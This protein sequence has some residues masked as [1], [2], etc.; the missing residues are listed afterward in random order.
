M[1]RYMTSFHL[2]GIIPVSSIK[3]QYDMTWHPSLLPL[4]E[5]YNLVHRAIM[6]CAWAGCETIWI[7]MDPDITPIFRKIVGDYVFDPVNYYRS[8]DVDK[9]AKRVQIPVYFT[10]VDIKNRDKRDCY[11]WSIIDGAH[12]AYKVSKQLS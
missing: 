7:V 9:R 8:M 6:E 2:A 11:G 4:D 3:Q 12:M 1:V 10:T 5:G